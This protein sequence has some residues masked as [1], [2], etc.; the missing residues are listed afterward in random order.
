MGALLEEID[1]ALSSDAWAI[2]NVPTPERV[3]LQ[4]DAAALRHC[5]A[6]LEEIEAAARRGRELSVRVLART[7]I[8]AF[9]YALYIHF[10]GYDAVMRIQQDTRR[11]PETTHR[12]LA[13]VRPTAQT[14]EEAADQAP[15]PN[16]KGQLTT[17]RR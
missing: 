9:L 13:R 7:H 15:L 12:D 4:Y 6:L 2:L 11:S 10:G 8:E 3:H 16:P 17:K 5:A 1:E 14:R